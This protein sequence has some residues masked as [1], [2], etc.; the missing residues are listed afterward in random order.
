MT[1]DEK[2]LAGVT[3]LGVLLS[4]VGI[5]VPL[6]IYLFQQGR[7]S[8]VMRHAKQALGY[9]VV[10]LLLSFLLGIIFTGGMMGGLMYGRFISL[11]SFGVYGLITLAFILYGI[12]GGIQGFLGREFKYIWIGD[13]IERI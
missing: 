4:G 2:I 13:F 6:V 9:Q 3:H 7:S 8:F 11:G 5:V 12:A 1:S 10:V